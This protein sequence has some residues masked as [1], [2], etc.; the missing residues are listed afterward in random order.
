MLTSIVDSRVDRFEL[1][2]GPPPSH[3][4]WRT[5]CIPPWYS[6]GMS[7]QIT[8]RLPDALV[9]YVDARVGDGAAASRASVVTTALERERRRHLAEQDAEILAAEAVDPDLDGLAEFV[10]S[11]PM[12]HLD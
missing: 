11:T 12:D 7:T 9:E 2:Y 3:E 8:V 6:P 1:I 5:G 10:V 4:V